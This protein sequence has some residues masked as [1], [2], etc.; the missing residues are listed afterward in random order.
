MQVVIDIPEEIY[1]KCKRIGDMNNTWWN[2]PYE[3]SKA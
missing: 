1:E 3:G 2:T